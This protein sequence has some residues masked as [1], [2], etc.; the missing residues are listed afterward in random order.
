VKGSPATVVV[1]V[2]VRVPEIIYIL[3]QFGSY[4]TGGAEP[5]RFKMEICAPKEAVISARAIAK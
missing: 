5:E 1:L 4:K 2:T 3:P